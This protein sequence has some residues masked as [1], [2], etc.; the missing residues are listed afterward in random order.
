MSFRE[1]YI[2][3][4]P[5]TAVSNQM[6]FLFIRTHTQPI[7]RDQTT[8]NKPNQFRNTGRDSLPSL[9]KKE[10]DVILKLFQT[11]MNFFLSA[12]QKKICFF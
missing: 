1:H 3:S 9:P 7:Q 8:Y 12:E 10:N 4:S 5:R 11:G 6:L 2:I